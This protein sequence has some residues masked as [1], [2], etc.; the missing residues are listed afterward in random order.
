MQTNAERKGSVMGNPAREA[1]RTE[2]LEAEIDRI[3]ERRA[4]ERNDANHIEALW[5]SSA[6]RH[7]EQR[8]RENGAAWY[9]H[10]VALSDVHRRLAEEHEA[11][12]L[13][14]LEVR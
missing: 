6:G 14:L 3:I 11:E 4:R 12:A 13:K 5:K 7:N 2:K 10:H 9:A 1:E 8:R